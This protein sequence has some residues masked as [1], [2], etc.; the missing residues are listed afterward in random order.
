MIP[1]KASDLD[2]SIEEAGRQSVELDALLGSLPPQALTWRPSDEKWS[3]AGHVA[4]LCLL[5]ERYL[6]ALRERIA[7]A[8]ADGGPRSDGPYRHPWLARWFARSMEPPPKRR[9]KTMRSM[10]PDPSLVTGDV[11]GRFARLQDELA[12]AMEDARGLDLGAAR[13]PSPFLSLLRLS[14][15]TAFEALLAHNRRHIWLVREVLDGE[16]FPRDE[17]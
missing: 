14:L 3:A 6:N 16:G 7:R 2:G 11:L 8:R 10:V 1:T 9:M 17:G 15:G 12:A 5:N 13:F 4:H